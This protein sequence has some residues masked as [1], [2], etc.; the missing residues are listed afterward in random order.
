MS[1]P[2]QGQIDT[3]DKNLPGGQGEIA[4]SDSRQSLQ[5]LQQALQNN[6]DIPQE[7]KQALPK[8]CMSIVL[9]KNKGDRERLRASEILRAMSRDNVEALTALDRIERLDGG[10]ATDRIEL[11]PIKWNPRS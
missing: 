3:S 1:E 9:D 11:G 4:L 2:S 7:W 6:W 5:M 8:F 10:E